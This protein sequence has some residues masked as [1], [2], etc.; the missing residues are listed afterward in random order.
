MSSWK[1]V[2]TT[3]D[4]SNTNIG[5]SDLTVPNSTTRNLS[6][7]NSSSK[8]QIKNSNNKVFLQVL[9]DEIVIGSSHADCERTVIRSAGSKFTVA[10]DN[11]A[12]FT[13]TKEFRV[14]MLADTD[15]AGIWPGPVLQ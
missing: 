3:D 7:G 14:A 12:K 11:T 6:L 15:D 8:F 13:L 10:D 4:V 5:S 2:L 1:R 9:D